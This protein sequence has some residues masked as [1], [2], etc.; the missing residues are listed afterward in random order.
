MAPRERLSRGQCDRVRP[1]ESGLSLVAPSRP[2]ALSRV[3]GKVRRLARRGGDDAIRRAPARH[4]LELYPE[5]AGM[6]VTM[7]DVTYRISNLDPSKLYCL[8]AIAR[9][10]KP[11]TVF[12]F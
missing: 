6:V 1:M 3:A 9:I 2:T 11:R 7:G 4:L 12:E 10:R 5:A 8:A